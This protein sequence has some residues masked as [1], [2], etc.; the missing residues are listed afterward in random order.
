[1]T[2]VNILGLFVMACGVTGVVWYYYRVTSLN[3]AVKNFHLDRFNAFVPWFSFEKEIETR[4]EEFESHL[5]RLIQWETI[6]VKEETNPR[7]ACIRGNYGKWFLVTLEVSAG[8]SPGK[9]RI[10]CQ[11]FRYKHEYF[12]F[13]AGTLTGAGLLVAGS[14]YLILLL[15]VS[16][17]MLAVCPPIYFLYWFMVRMWLKHAFYRKIAIIEPNLDMQET[18]RRT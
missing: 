6:R 11:T 7:W 15:L 5:K 12:F 18:R 16:M 10:R 13:V 9:I 8:I 4:P 3:G 1:M 2:W 14:G 17:F